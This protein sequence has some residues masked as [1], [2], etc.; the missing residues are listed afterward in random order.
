MADSELC[1]GCQR[2]N[3]DIK[4]VSW[5]SD[6][7]ELVCKSCARAHERMSPP[8]K[9][10]PM[11]EIQQLSSS[12]LKLSKNCENHPDQ[13]IVLF[14][15][16]HD[17]VICDSC[18]PV[19]HQ[20]CK[21]IISIEKAA[22]G[23]KDST[24]ISDL[25]RRLDN[26]S[27]VTDNIL[28]KTGITLNN[29]TKSRNSIKKRVTEMKQRV[30]AHLD[31]IEADILKDIDT[32][33]KY[34]ND[35]VSRNEYGVKS[36]IHSLSTWKRDLKSLK[37]NTS[38]IHLFRAVKFLDAKTHQKELDIREIQ[39]ATVPILTYH[40]PEEESNM[41]K[42]I[43]DLGTITVDNIP[44]PMSVLDIDQQGQFLVKNEKKLSLTHSIQTTKLG[45]GDYIDSGCFIP[46][47]SLLLGD[48]S[49]KKLYVCKLD[50]S[51]PKIIN[52]DSFPQRITLYD[53]NHAVVSVDNEGIQIINL[54][55]KPGRIIKVDGICI[56]I[57]CVKDKIWVKN[58][59]NTLTIVDIDGRV[60]NTIQTTFNPWNIC[61]NK[62]GDVYCTDHYSDKVYLITSDGKEREIY[63]SPDLRGTDDVVVDDRGDVYVS[64]YKSNNIH[65][66]SNDGHDIVLTADDGIKQPY[67]LSYNCE[68]RELLVINNNYEFGFISK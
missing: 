15:C 20:N 40:P 47:E 41:K 32:K 25:E 30:L 31:K 51:K 8:H 62:D 24:A 18:V 17:K 68:T 6:C 67:G 43:Q 48:S 49:G 34:C 37:Q 45:D 36:S 29:L 50:G 1:A 21:P 22:R 60:L 28:G 56:G 66:I 42:L 33:Y 2:H 58:Q 44:V 55:L 13:K 64:G 9:V 53:H 7:S 16:Q 57:T 4:A 3:E 39:K 59:D 5:C 14:C 35:T 19:S 61:A 63:S 12:L 27:K 11:K 38:E 46:G 26:L 23:V 54:T 10:V 52:L 65:R